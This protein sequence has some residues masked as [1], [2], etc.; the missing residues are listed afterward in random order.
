MK[1]LLSVFVFILYAGILLAQSSKDFKYSDQE[2]TE[3]FSPIDEKIT[4]KNKTNFQL[5]TGT[6]IGM[7]SGKNSFVNIF[8]ASHLSYSLS[9][10]LNIN[11][12]AMFANTRFQSTSDKSLTQSGTFN[13]RNFMVGMDYKIS[14]KI[15]IG[16]SLQIHNGMNGMNTLGQPFSPTFSPFNIWY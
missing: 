10:V 13:N 12:S 15:T 16:A 11:A 3:Y 6:S 8:V 9:P 4:Q 5:I 1:K 7:M 14:E 2:K